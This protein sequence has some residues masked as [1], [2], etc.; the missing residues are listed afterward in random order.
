MLENILGS[1]FGLFKTISEFSFFNQIFIRL[2]LS[3]SL[4][5]FPHMV[6]LRKRCCNSINLCCVKY[7]RAP[8]PIRLC[9][10]QLLIRP[11]RINKTS[12]RPA[13]LCWSGQYLLIQGS[14]TFF[15]PHKSQRWF[16]F[17]I[18]LHSSEALT[19]GRLIRPRDC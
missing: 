5:V 9:L 4:H 3:P 14:P 7:L 2:C 19:G 15:P 18:F 1:I 16:I 10:S 6:F 11:A 8:T 17:L 13:V 12:Q